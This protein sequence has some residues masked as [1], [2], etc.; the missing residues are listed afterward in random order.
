[1]DP[2]VT[3]RQA[4]AARLL[5]YPQKL[6]MAALTLSAKNW[7]RAA[8][9]RHSSTQQSGVSSVSRLLLWAASRAQAVRSTPFT[10]TGFCGGMQSVGSTAAQ[11]EAAVGVW[12]G[13]LSQ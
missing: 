10:L 11:G 5:S 8:R 13:V 7:G 9:G 4:R 3:V 1:M 2:R 12:V 6:L